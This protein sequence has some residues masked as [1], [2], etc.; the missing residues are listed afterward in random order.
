MMRA[1]QGAV[2]VVP[3]SAIDYHRRL[4]ASIGRRDLKI[5]PISFLETDQWRGWEMTALLLDHALHLNQ[6]QT[7]LFVQIRNLRIRG[8]QTGD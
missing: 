6:Y 2:Y 4:A 7:D 8:Q 3:A 5:V 1:P